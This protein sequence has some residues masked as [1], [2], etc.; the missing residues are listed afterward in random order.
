M[1]IKKYTQEQFNKLRDFVL[2]FKKLPEEK[3][4]Q[5]PEEKLRPVLE[6][7]REMVEYNRKMQDKGKAKV[8]EITLDPS[9]KPL[10]KRMRHKNYVASDLSTTFSSPDDYNSKTPEEV[11]KEE[12]HQ[13]WLEE[14]NKKLQERYAAHKKIMS[15]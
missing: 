3:Q 7:F 4:K 11:K 15:F 5:V 10:P 13:K 6:T 14:H 12:D 9:Q 8:K 1:D 2:N